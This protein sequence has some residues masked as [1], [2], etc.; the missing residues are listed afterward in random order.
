MIAPLKHAEIW[1]K[2]QLYT[3]YHRYWLVNNTL[4]RRLQGI[5]HI[6][7]SAAPGAATGAAYST[8]CASGDWC[9]DANTLRVTVCN[10]T[11]YAHT[12]THTFAHHFIPQ[13]AAFIFYFSVSPLTMQLPLFLQTLT[14]KQKHNVTAH[15]ERSHFPLAPPLPPC[16]SIEVVLVSR[17]FH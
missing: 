2:H 3:C 15:Y 1:Y 13:K 5:T 6:H 9:T 14:A 17:V 11:A 8:S 7:T 4:Y 16:L 12:H 10:Q